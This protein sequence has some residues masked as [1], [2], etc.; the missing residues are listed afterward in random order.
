MSS[1]TIRFREDVLV[2]LSAHGTR[3]RRQQPELEDR[4]HGT[5]VGL[6]RRRLAAKRIARRARGVVSHS[7]SP[8][9]RVAVRP[10]REGSSFS[11]GRISAQRIAKE[12]FVQGF[13]IAEDD[14]TAAA[15]CTQFRGRVRAIVL[16]GFL[17]ANRDHG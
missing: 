16:T 15:F 2:D 11:F 6:E 1:C 17:A 8:V 10:K 13:V 12:Q 9:R 14:S 5:L 7:L 4:L 3:V